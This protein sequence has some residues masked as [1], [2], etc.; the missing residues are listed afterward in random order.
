MPHVT[1]ISLFRLG[2][3]ISL[4]GVLLC[5][6]LGLLL[7]TPF[8]CRNT[9]DDVVERILYDTDGSNPRWPHGALLRVEL[10][11]ANVEDV[12]GSA[13]VF[14]HCSLYIVFPV[15]LPNRVCFPVSSSARSS[16]KK[17]CELFV[18]RLLLLAMPS[19]PRRLNL[20]RP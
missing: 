9:R 10:E 7:S 8:S 15:I 19:N 18:L 1:C 20:S 11:F 16:V 14:G 13:G 17:N 2:P 3:L 6:N 12:L 5:F 4:L